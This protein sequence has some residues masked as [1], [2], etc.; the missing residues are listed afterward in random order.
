MDTPYCDRELSEISGAL[1]AT[2]E[3]PADMRGEAFEFATSR[4]TRATMCGPDMAQI[5]RDLRDHFKANGPDAQRR[6]LLVK[7][8]NE[9]RNQASSKWRMP[10]RLAAH[11]DQARP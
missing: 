5:V 1:E 9:A 4:F 11:L 6:E 8:A 7:F 10:A 3:A 2:L